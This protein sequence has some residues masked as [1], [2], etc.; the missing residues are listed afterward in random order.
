MRH[1]HYILAMIAAFA[2]EL[3]VFA[4]IL[5]SHKSPSDIYFEVVLQALFLFVCVCFCLILRQCLMFQCDGERS[6]KVTFQFVLQ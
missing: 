5:H 4:L 3:F 6:Q 1:G 2:A